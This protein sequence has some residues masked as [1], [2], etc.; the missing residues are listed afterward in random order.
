M[1][2]NYLDTAFSPYR[3]YMDELAKFDR[4]NEK[5]SVEAVELYNYIDNDGQLYN[6]R[7]MPIW[8]NYTKKMKAG[9]YNRALAEKG[10]LPFVTDGAKKYAKEIAREKNANAWQ[11]MFPMKVR[12]EVASMLADEFEDHYETKYFDFMK[13]SINE[14]RA[15]PEQN[16]TLVKLEKKGFREVG[17]FRDGDDTVYV[18]SISSKNKHSHFQCEVEANGKIFGTDTFEKFWRENKDYVEKLK[19][20]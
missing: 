1:K 16:E 15:T 20:R 14:Q 10:M 18:M 6:Q 19:R 3:F 9:K 5:K 4:L 12:K 17:H 11:N 7:K 8:K 13:E 2:D